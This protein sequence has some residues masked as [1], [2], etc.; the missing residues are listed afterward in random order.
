MDQK[1]P[2]AENPL[3]APWTGPFEAPPFDRLKP[4][5]FEPAFEAAL[6]S[7]QAEVAAIAANPDPPSFENTIEALERS[8]RDLDRVCRRFL[9]SRSGRY[10]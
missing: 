3:L 7:A 2:L 8:G 9:Q 5:D 10:Q 4:S 1:I 6:A